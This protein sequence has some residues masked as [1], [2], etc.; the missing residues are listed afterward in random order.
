M[1][2]KSETQSQESLDWFQCF[3]SNYFKIVSFM[4]IFQI[5]S[6]KNLNAF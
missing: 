3:H 6:C 1:R 2:T 5:L 4:H